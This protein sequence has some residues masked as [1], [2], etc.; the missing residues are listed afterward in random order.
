MVAISTK[1]RGAYKVSS[2]SLHF[3]GNHLVWTVERTQRTFRVQIVEPNSYDATKHPAIFD[4]AIQA[5]LSPQL[6]SINGAAPRSLPLVG[7]PFDLMTFPEA[8]L[9]AEHLL[10]SLMQLSRLPSIGC[11][12][13]GL[14]PSTQ[15]SHLFTTSDLRTLRDSLLRTPNIDPKDLEKFSYWLD[16]QPAERRFNVACLF[17]IDSTGRLRLCLHPKLQR[18]KFE[19]SA[20]PENMMDEGSLLTVITLRPT[21]KR[22]L[23]VSLQPL[24]CSDVLLLGTDSGGSRP[25]EA[26]HLDAECLGEDP[27]DHID[28]VSVVACTPQNENR[29]PRPHR[30]WKSAFKEAFH[31]AATDDAVSRHRFATFVVANFGLDPQRR[32]GGLSGVFFPINPS[33]KFPSAMSV[34]CWGKPLGEADLRWSNPTED[35]STWKVKGHIASLD[36]YTDGSGSV[37]RMLGLTFAAL[38]RG[39]SLW[40]QPLGIGDCQI[41]HGKYAADQSIVFDETDYG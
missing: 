35:Y 9:P 30:T 37:A 18:S 5:F 20:L 11:V 19:F 8:F 40:H 29:E 22:F 14:L 33:S 10:A 15:G 24:I 27:P 36:P 13:V 4:A 38:P 25:L 1:S 26:V 16:S 31:R 28:V 3:C 39:M 6:S 2:K 12:H 32:P 21:D 17:T 23:T 7:E 34:S 41:R